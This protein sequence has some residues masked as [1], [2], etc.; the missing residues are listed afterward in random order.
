VAVPRAS[1][2]SGVQLSQPSHFGSYTPPPAHASAAGNVA[3]AR[4][5]IGVIG[6]GSPNDPNASSHSERM[7]TSVWVN[8]QDL[9]GYALTG[10][11]DPQ[12][13]L[14][15]EGGEPDDR[16][17]QGPE[18]AGRESATDEKVGGEK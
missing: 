13:A 18:Q 15:D 5:S 17:D 12:H 3:I 10:K 4:A 11:V 2:L 6:G 16:D 9:S 8:R 7:N 1:V 14:S